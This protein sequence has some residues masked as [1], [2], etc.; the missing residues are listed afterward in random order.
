MDAVN[1]VIDA[2][3]IVMVFTK[4]LKCK[5]RIIVQSRVNMNHRAPQTA[6]LSKEILVPL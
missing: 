4:S 3:K 2:I 1:I 5:E 6:M